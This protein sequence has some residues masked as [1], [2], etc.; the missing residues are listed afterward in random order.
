MTSPDSVQ[1]I[2]PYRNLPLIGGEHHSWDVFGRDDQLGTLNFIRPDAVTKAARSVSEGRVI[3]L[4]LPLDLPHP[5]LAPGR[6]RYDHEI[7]RERTGRDDKVNN[8]YLQCS[9]QWDSLQH[10]RFREFGYY[11]G[12]EEDE[13]DRGA[14]GIDVMA[15]NG[16]IGRGILLDV[17]RY[18]RQKGRG[19]DAR[20]RLPI[21]AALLDE[22]ATTQGIEPESGDILL[23]RTGWLTWYLALDQAGSE[24]PGGA[25]FS[26]Q[27]HGAGPRL[28]VQLQ[29]RSARYGGRHRNN[30][31]RHSGRRAGPSSRQGRL[32]PGQRG[33][34]DRLRFLSRRRPERGCRAA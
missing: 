20:Q 15:R 11:G 4:S 9:S 14:L 31:D 12:R 29:L 28:S 3:C 22:V 30:C 32:R 13:L 27:Q 24:R 19:F 10:I 8:F 5:A 2:P 25:I 23:L 18:L 16:I 21:S 26:D 17:E 1:I 6:A 7:I 33:L 34:R